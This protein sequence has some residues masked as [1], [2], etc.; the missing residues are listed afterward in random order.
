MTLAEYGDP[1]FHPGLSPDCRT[2]D[3]DACNGDAWVR[4]R[5]AL[6]RCECRCHAR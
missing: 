3:C 1:I 6:G 5:D 2:G 4:D